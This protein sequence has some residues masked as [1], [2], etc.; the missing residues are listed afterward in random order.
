[1]TGGILAPTLSTQHYAMRL[2]GVGEGSYTVFILM[3][4]C[5]YILFTGFVVYVKLTGSYW[6]TWN[7]V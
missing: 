3:L 6:I 4:P 7:H 2:E 5:C 1:M